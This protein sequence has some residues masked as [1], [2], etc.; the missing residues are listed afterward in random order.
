MASERAEEIKRQ[1]ANPFSQQ[2][3][4]DMA[5]AIEVGEALAP[6]WVKAQEAGIDVSAQKQQADQQLAQIRAIR[7]V[8]TNT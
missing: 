2:D 1:I 3:L 7:D 8:F 6:L 4:A 5:D